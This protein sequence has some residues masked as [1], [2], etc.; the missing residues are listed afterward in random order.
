MGIDTRSLS[1]D[2]KLLVTAEWVNKILPGDPFDPDQDDEANVLIWLLIVP[3]LVAGW[4][5]ILVC[6][7]YMCSTNFKQF[8][9]KYVC[10][11]GESST[12]NK[13]MW[14]SLFVMIHIFLSLAFVVWGLTLYAENDLDDEKFG[15]AVFSLINATWFIAS[16]TT[17]L[18]MFFYMERNQRLTRI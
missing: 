8:Y 10:A 5:P 9:N 15:L 12:W 18:K 11:C 4:L 13:P 16:V 3:L 6:I 14:K 17:A 1:E 7:L 2:E